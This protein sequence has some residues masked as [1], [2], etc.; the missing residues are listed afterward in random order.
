[1]Q[2]DSAP[3]STKAKNVALDHNNGWDIGFD[4]GTISFR[5]SDV[6]TEDRL[7]FICQRVFG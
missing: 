6:K 7:D 4:G 5:S 1:M 2:M 3:P